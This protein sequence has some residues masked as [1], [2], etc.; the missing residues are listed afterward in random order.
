MVILELRR[1]GMVVTFL[2]LSFII[3]LLQFCFSHYNVNLLTQY[4][5][6]YGI[7]FINKV[8]AVL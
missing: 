4:Y 8:F 6:D 5:S 2:F 7:L 1:Q 3:T